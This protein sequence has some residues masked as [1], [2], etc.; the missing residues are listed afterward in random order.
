MQ[1]L[2][3]LLGTYF[4]RRGDMA[5]AG[6]MVLVV[7][8]SDIV[9]PWLV[10]LAID[11]IVGVTEHAGAVPL[12]A[13]RGV[14]VLAGLMVSLGALQYVV[15]RRLARVQNRVMF[16]GAANLRAELYGRLQAQ[17]LAFHARRRVGGLLNALVT[18]IQT[19]QD[20]CSELVAVVPFA[21]CILVG[22][23]VA[24]TLIHPLM[25][26][27][28]A[29]FLGWAFWMSLHIGR[30]GWLSQAQAMH[31]AEA[32]TVQAQE[33]FGGM[34][35]LKS[36]GAQAG[37]QT[38]LNV[39]AQNHAQAQQE[40][41]EVRATVTPF[42]GL[43]EYAGIL[44][45]LVGGGW[46]ALHGALTA[47]GLV[48][49]LAYMEMTADPIARIADLFPKLQR[50]VMAADRVQTLLKETAPPAMRPD[51]ITPGVILGR[52]CATHLGF[53]YADGKSA[54]HDIRFEVQPGERVAIVGPNAAG[55][56]TL[57]DL[58]LKLATPT[59]GRV[60]VDGM[61]LAN[62]S[63]DA[64]CRLAGVV[65]QDVYLLNRTVAE[66]IALGTALIADVE[67][68]ARQAGVD[69]V[70][71]RLPLGYETVPG[72]RGVCLSGGERQRIAIARVFLR[73]PRVVLLDEPT[74]ALDLRGE[75]ELLPALQRLCA[76]RTS[77]IVSHR[78]PVIADV[79]KVLLLSEGRQLAFDRPGNI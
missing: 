10:K 61:D 35:A 47:G 39:A 44:I 46:L 36:F 56:S 70:I 54:L 57:L 65:P 63:S 8:A 38:E 22:L 19:L 50:A 9:S 78:A 55:K 32:L 77:F 43:A 52:I 40:A 20:M 62:I 66:N 53:A 13:F 18:D 11:R 30:R 31:A 12:E 59:G 71:R 68:A 37:A 34:R 79:D 41:G 15:R 48:A 17:P 33:S 73:N 51:L 23:L 21:A 24:M 2:T 14:L 67:E 74:S 27:P 69:E 42:F 75:A 1:S 26:L 76:G 28:V 29:A 6:G 16:A 58:L 72:E 60:E 45:V 7:A 3:R 64:W 4:F 25:A 49:L 5:L